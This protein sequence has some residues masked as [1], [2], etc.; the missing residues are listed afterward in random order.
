MKTAQS[1]LKDVIQNWERLVSVLYTPGSEEMNLI[2]REFNV[3]I[4]LHGCESSLGEIDSLCSSMTHLCQQRE[5][6]VQSL[7]DKSKQIEEFGSVMV[8]LPTCICYTPYIL[9]VHVHVYLLI[10]QSVLV[11]TVC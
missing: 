10:E 8:R 5:I 1:H 3:N 7:K 6:M 11:Y 9:N 2:K 4:E